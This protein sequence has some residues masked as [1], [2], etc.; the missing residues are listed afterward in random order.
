V[1][2][3][4]KGHILRRIETWRVAGDLLQRERWARLRAMTDD[5]SRKAVAE[6]LSPRSMKPAIPLIEAARE[7]ESILAEAGMKAVIIGGLAVF[8]WGEPRLTRDVDFTVLCPFGA[9]GP[10]IHAILSHLSGRIEDAAEFATRNRVLLATAA[11]GIPV[12]IALG[13]LPYEARAVERGSTFEYVPGA[14]LRA[15]TGGSSRMSSGR[16][17]R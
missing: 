3:S 6:L 1:D 16:C 12:D 14:P 11:N 5:D 2:E 10:G 17:S 9:E 13:G 4:E 15:S 7:V 8:R